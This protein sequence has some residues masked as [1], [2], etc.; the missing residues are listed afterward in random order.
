MT[1]HPRIRDVGD[2]AFSIAFDDGAGVVALNAAILQAGRLAGLVET[3]PSLLSLLVI[4]DPS[5]VSRAA[6]EEHV[7]MLA[8][9]TTTGSAVQGRSWRIPVVYDGPD[10]EDVAR[11]CGLTPPQVIQLHSGM[12]YEVRMLGFMPGFAYMGT[13]PEALRLPRRAEPRL[14]VP[15]G[16]LAMADDM[17]AIYPWESPGGWHLL[18]RAEAVLFDQNREPPALLAAGDRV[19]F[20]PQ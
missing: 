15:A 18:G 17:T 19:E 1:D 7:R 3:I 2:T 13:L 5:R 8:A 11:A 16:S 12:V 20:V 10:L 9:T 6:M 14:K 4:F